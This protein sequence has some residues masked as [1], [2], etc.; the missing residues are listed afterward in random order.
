MKQ[1]LLLVLSLFIVVSAQT[2]LNWSGYNDT[3]VITGFKYDS[4]RITKA[5]NFTNA[6][7]KL[8][9]FIFDD[10]ANAARIN[11]SVA[12]E[13]GVQTGVPFRNLS[14]LMDTLWSNN[15]PI[16]TCNTLTANKRYDHK[17]YAGAPIWVID[18]ASNPIKPRGQIDTTL[19]TSSSAMLIP[20]VNYWAP[21]VRFYLK[22]LTGNAHTAIRARII[23]TQRNY[24]MV[25]VK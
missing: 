8:A 16:D 7:E 4:L 5:F 13:I 18:E 12:C 15:C 3:A 20:F 19:G 21:Y 1:F 9:I 22:G 24:S 23:F 6:E 10:T 14:N 2:D 25:R 11:D 17:K